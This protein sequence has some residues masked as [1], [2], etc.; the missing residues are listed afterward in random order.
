MSQSRS[1][2]RQLT[3]AA[4]VTLGCALAALL[5]GVLGRAW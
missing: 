3:T 1:R 4:T 5:L 2:E